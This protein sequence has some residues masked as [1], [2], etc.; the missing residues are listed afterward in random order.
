M[1]LKGPFLNLAQSSAA[2]AE[3]GQASPRRPA[4]FGVADATYATEESALY[5]ETRFVAV[6]AVAGCR[7]Q[8][9]NHFDRAAGCNLAMAEAPH[10]VSSCGLATQDILA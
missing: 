2:D 1:T 3:V 7:Q 4:D 5:A 10:S 9:G 6:V 8:K